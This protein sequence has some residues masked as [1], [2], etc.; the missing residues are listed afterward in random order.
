SDL[1][2]IAGCRV[3][4]PSLVDVEHVTLECAKLDVTRARDYRDSDRNGYRAVHLTIRASDGNL[5]ELQIRTRIQHGW[6][7][8]TE[9]AA[10]IAGIEVKYG[11][12]P[13]DIRAL[14]DSFSKMVR[15]TDL[16]DYEL[17]AGAVFEEIVAG[18]VDDLELEAVRS[19]REQ[20]EVNATEQEASLLRL[21]ATLFP[22]SVEPQ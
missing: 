19:Y 12:G 16:R 14:L 7:Q 2:D 4:V 22:E 20:I 18:Q 8:L 9:R 21:W 3:I 13:D 1:E 11:G 17:R 15:L 6:A 10:A 5:V